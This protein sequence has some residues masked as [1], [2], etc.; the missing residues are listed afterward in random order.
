MCHYD[1]YNKLAVCRLQHAACQTY[2]LKI[3]SF[4][5]IDMLTSLNTCRL[6]PATCRMSNSYNDNIFFWCLNTIITINLPLAACHMPH[7][8]LKHWQYIL[9]MSQ[10]DDKLAA[11]R[12]PHAAWQTC[13]LI[14]LFF[15]SQYAYIIINFSLAACR[16]WYLHIE[17]ISFQYNN[18]DY[19]ATCRLSLFWYMAR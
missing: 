16:I 9:L 5:Y 17:H 11:C 13:T 12:L 14:F 15:V 6:L 8:K 19:H 1:H 10:Y 4:S 3:F 18:L 2:T 7:V